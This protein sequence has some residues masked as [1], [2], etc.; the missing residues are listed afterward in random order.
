[1]SEKEHRPTS[2]LLADLEVV[3]HATP[4][5]FDS[6]TELHRLSA[7]QRLVWLDEA[8]AFIT[9]AQRAKAAPAT[10]H[11]LPATSATLLFLFML[12]ASCPMLP[13]RR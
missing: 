4:G 10:R 1:M 12:S 6:H 3:R 5:D 9:A 2:R 8:V 13:A 11:Q 7:R